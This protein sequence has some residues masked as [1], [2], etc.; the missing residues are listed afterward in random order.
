MERTQL[1]REI[2]ETCLEMTRL[3]L[4]QGTAGNV[5]ARYQDGM[6]ITPSGVPYERMTEKMIVFVGNDGDYEEGKL[7]S[8]EWR[9]HLAA[10]QTRPDAYAVVHNHAIHCTAVSILN[11]PIPAIHYMIAA[12]GGNSIPCAPYATFGTRELSEHVAV[13]LRNRKATLLQHHGLIACEANLQKA[14]WLAHEV[15]VLAQLYLS[16]LAVVDPV[17]VLSDEEIAVVLEKFKT[18]GLRIEE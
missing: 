3:G 15:E 18:Y 16:T 2:I 13:A 10:Y 8:S 1:S 14:L 9:F 17:P 11:R 5:S 12:A 4:N 6:L 7:P